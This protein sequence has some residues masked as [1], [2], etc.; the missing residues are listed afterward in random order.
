M[1][2]KAWLEFYQNR[3]VHRYFS[4]GVL[5][6]LHKLNFALKEI[7]NELAQKCFLCIKNIY[8]DAFYYHKQEFLDYL[9]N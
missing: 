8:F 4:R 7:E 5:L 9:K 1:P 6:T 3:Y 2:M